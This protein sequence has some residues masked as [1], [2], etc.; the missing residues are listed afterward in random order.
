MT[1]GVLQ[2]LVQSAVK[3]DVL[4]GAIPTMLNQACKDIE[5][6]RSFRGM[7]TTLKF[8]VVSGASDYQLPSTFKEPQSGYDPMIVSTQD[9]AEATTWKLQSKQEIER[10]QRIGIATSD[11]QAFIDYSTDPPTLVLPAPALVNYSVS[12]DCYQFL[13][14]LTK[15]APENWLTREYPMAVLWHAIALMFGLDNQNPN[16][17]QLVQMYEQKYAIAFAA[18][19]ADDA[20]REVRGRSYRMGGV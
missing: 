7:K 16:A 11:R 1:L 17:A 9:D 12:I 6:A 19:S 18:A 20:F 4:Y 14:E 2:S 13:P 3:N 15:T 10:L 8:T 5:Q